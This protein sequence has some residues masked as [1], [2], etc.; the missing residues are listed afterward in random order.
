MTVIHPLAASSAPARDHCRGCG[1]RLFR[2]GDP[3]A[4]RRTRIFKLERETLLLRCP[5]GMWCP[6][7]RHL[8]KVLLELLHVAG[9]ET[10]A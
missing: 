2:P 5:C 10:P 4:A 8:R 6:I 1:N 3:Q 9:Q 7:P